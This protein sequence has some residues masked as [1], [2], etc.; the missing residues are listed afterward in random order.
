MDADSAEGSPHPSHT[1]M[2]TMV[3]PVATPQM[4]IRSHPM[5]SGTIPALQHTQPIL[6]PAHTTIMVRP[7]P[8]TRSIILVA[9]VQVPIRFDIAPFSIVVPL[10]NSQS[11]LVMAN[12]TESAPDPA[13]A[14]V[15]AVSVMVATHQMPVSAHL[16]PA[17]AS[18]AAQDPQ[19]VQV[20]A[21][22]SVPTPEPTSR[23]VVMVASPQVPVRAHAT[24][25]ALIV[26]IECAQ[27]VQVHANSPESAPSP[28]CSSMQTVVIMVA[29]PQVPIGAHLYPFGSSPT[30]QDA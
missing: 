10:E 26:A 23:L 3:E 20:I 29:T 8:T 14:P 6:V 17:G 12:A 4:P 25:M 1:S 15:Q 21:N 30:L 28:L 5:P 2:L 18:P 27:A 24:P 19:A 11:V 13:S 16:H 22:S 9:T 7:E